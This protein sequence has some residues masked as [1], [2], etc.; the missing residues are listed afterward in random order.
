[1]K[2][3]AVNQGSCIGC[4]ACVAIDSEHFGFSDEGLSEV[5][6]QENTESAEVQNAI[7]SCPTGAISY[8]EEET[9]ASAEPEPSVA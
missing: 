1:M 4:G 2:K 3:I 7:E 5:I 8:G 9:D 6:S